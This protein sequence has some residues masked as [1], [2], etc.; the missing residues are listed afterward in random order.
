M[1]KCFQVAVKGL[2]K[3]CQGILLL[4]RIA[5]SYIFDLFEGRIEAAETVHTTLQREFVEELPTIN[6]C[7]VG[8]VVGAYRVHI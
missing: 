8:S 3:T 6:T 1:T 7:T 2:V 5:T 4:K